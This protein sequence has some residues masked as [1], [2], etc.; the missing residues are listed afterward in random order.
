MTTDL[1]TYTLTK[2]IAQE[3]IELIKF[4]H[5]AM[6]YAYTIL[7]FPESPGSF[8]ELGY[9]AY[10]EVL[11]KKIITT[12]NYVH[13]NT[14]SYVNSLIDYIHEQKSII[15]R[16]IP[17]AN[18]RLKKADSTR[19]QEECKYI[20][21]DIET[22]YDRVLEERGEL[23]TPISNASKNNISSLFLLYETIRIF[24]MLS[25][26]ELRQMYKIVL[27]NF[28]VNYSENIYKLNISLLCVALV[29]ERRKE[30]N[31]TYFNIIKKTDFI[32]YSYSEEELQEIT[33]LN[34]AW[35]NIA[36]RKNALETVQ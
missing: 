15:A 34:I 17:F 11:R 3:S 31:I 13:C 12:K 6:D 36:R 25:Y 16:T 23:Y 14:Q 32:K 19:L 7:I 30:N 21:Q 9:F 28:S 35:I 4:E 33:Y 20:I 10:D 5:Q 18:K 29:I 2:G 22:S 27:E 26:R 8:S 1:R 24:P